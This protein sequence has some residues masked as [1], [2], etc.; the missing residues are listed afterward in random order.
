[1]FTTGCFILLF[2]THM[3]LIEKVTEVW[4]VKPNGGNPEIKH[5]KLRWNVWKT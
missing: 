2:M 4:N 5:Y 1:M 3:Q